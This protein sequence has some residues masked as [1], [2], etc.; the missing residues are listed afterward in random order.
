MNSLAIYRQTIYEVHNRRDS[1]ADDDKIGQ[2]R[3]LTSE[4][5][6]RDNMNKS[7]RLLD[8]SEYTS[9]YQSL[10][11]FPILDIYRFCF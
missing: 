3:I 9:R 11:L 10:P 2:I 7:W 1:T 5:G 4:P 8:I 6:R